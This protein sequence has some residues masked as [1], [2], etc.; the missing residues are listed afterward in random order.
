[1]SD[2]AR[3]PRIDVA[4]APDAVRP[5]F[6][7]FVAARGKV[8]NLFRVAAHV[9]DMTA[10]LAALLGA[11]TG[12]GEVPTLLKEL[13]SARVSHLN[14]CDYCL[15]SHSLLARKLGGTDGQLEAVA[16]GDYTLFEESWRAAFRYADAMTTTPGIVPDDV[17]AG[18]AAHWNAVQIVEITAVV[19]MFAF[20]NRFANALA[21]PVTR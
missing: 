20:F 2:E 16:L 19:C 18:L 14:L 4:Q 15:A 11:V 3:L 1:M 8:P 17:Y 10:K 5:T 6:D 12:P 13:L 9:P 7:A 21:I